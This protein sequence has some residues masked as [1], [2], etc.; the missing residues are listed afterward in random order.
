M[1]TNVLEVYKG[2][3]VITTDIELGRYSYLC[4][5][6]EVKRDGRPVMVPTCIRIHKEFTCGCY[7]QWTDHCH[8][9]KRIKS[10]LRQKKCREHAK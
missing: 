7:K 8:S 2:R 6:E 9:D 10:S 4:E 5:T 1:S 3:R